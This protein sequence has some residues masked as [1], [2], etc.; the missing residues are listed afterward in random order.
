MSQ[1]SIRNGQLEIHKL[2]RDSPSLAGQVPQM[3]NDEYPPAQADVIDKT[4]WLNE[5][6]FPA[7]CPFTTEQALDAEF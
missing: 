7:H 3:L 2:L 4:G 5:Q 1:H 6:A